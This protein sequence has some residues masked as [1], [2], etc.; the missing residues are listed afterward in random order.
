M[1]YKK[2]VIIAA[3]IA[4]CFTTFVQAQE[5]DDRATILNF[6]G[7]QYTSKEIVFI[8][9]NIPNSLYFYGMIAVETRSI[10]FL[11]TL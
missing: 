3:T 10:K 8:K 6:K 5:R 4:V 2:T 9:P 1:I 7:I 11:R